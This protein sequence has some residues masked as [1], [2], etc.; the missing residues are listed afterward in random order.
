MDPERIHE[1]E[2][3]RA[4]DHAQETVED[5]AGP[6]RELVSGVGNQAFGAAVARQGAG[7]MPTGEVH[8]E[9]QSTINS[10]RGSGT[11]LDSGIADKLS[12][13]LGDLSDV[14]VHTD[15]TAQD[16]NHA[17]SAR[18]FATGT[19]VY[20]AQGEYKPN[21]M[22][23]DKLFGE[24]PEQSKPQADAAPLGAPR[25]RQPAGGQMTA[26]QTATTTDSIRPC[27]TTEVQASR[28]WTNTLSSDSSATP[29]NAI[30]CTQLTAPAR[31]SAKSRSSATPASSARMSPAVI[32]QTEKL[33]HC[34]SAVCE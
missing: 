4:P 32:S 31:P 18:A 6:L 26:R 29:A 20:F 11:T 12:P 17:V 5:P 15:S 34:M 10:T 25:M 27:G 22:D 21:T 19:D 28:L 24:L 8:P 30:K 14:R 16:L 33:A 2:K 1:H 7:I 23:G 13:S 3:P 9:V